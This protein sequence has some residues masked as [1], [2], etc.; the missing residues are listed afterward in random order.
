MTRPDSASHATISLRA[1]GRRILRLALPNIGTTVTRVLMGFIDFAMVSWLGTDAQAAISPASFLVFMAGCIGSGAAYC[2]TTFA[3]QALGRGERPEA[4]RFAWQAVYLAA[5]LGAVLTPL[6]VFVPAFYGWV[7][8]PAAVRDAEIDYTRIA[9]W[10]IAPSILV[11]GLDG[12]FNGVQRAGVSLAAAIIGLISNALLNYALI[13]GHWGCPRMGVAGAALATVIGWCVR[14][15]Y[16]FVFFLSPKFHESFA[17]R[18]GWRPSLHRLIQLIAIGLPTSLQWLLDL[19]AWVVFMTF[20]IAAYGTPAM[21]A[22]NLGVQYMHVSFMPAVGIGMALTSLVGHAIGEGRPERALVRA[23]AATLMCTA[24][25]GSV[26]LI[27]WLARSQLTQLLSSDPAVIQAGC[28][29]L[30]WSAVFQVFDAVGITYS[31]ALRGAGDTRWPA[32]IVVTYA[33]VIFIGGGVVL[34]RMLPGLGLHAPWLMCTLYVILI[35]VTLWW[36]WRR[37]GW[38]NIRLMDAMAVV[39]AS[40][41]SAS[42]TP[43]RWESMR[44]E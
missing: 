3:A 9:L 44:V 10:S 42:P 11:F 37:G 20:I 25:M 13:F 5:V 4:A 15:A 39:P 35:G 23:R 22:T 29:V 12:F 28:I 33:W 18:T 41:S 30:I 7:G 14:G 40:G 1:E 38:R 19:A 17:T 8:H 2:V 26:G 43:H 36:R 24:Y 34:G 16:L 21:A 27:F 6:I 31:S 32:F